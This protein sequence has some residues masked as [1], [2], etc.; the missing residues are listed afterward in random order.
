MKPLIL[1]ITVF[2]SIT[3]NTFAT[4]QAPDKIIYKGK[5][6]SLHT[7]PLEPYFEKHPDKKPKIKSTSSG[8][9]RGYIATFTIT[10]Q[11]M[12]LED[13]EIMVYVEKE[14]GELP[15]ERKSVVS[16]VIPKNKTLEIDWFTGVLVLPYGELVNYVHMGYGS[17]YESYILLEVK[18]GKVTG[19]RKFDYKQYETFKA[20]Q[21]DEYKKTVEYKKAFKELKEEGWEEDKIDAFLRSFIIRYTSEF[22]DK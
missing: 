14:E 5:E 21:F 20:K 7:N 13:I 15:F 19:K 1:A 11:V 8:C 3:I 17:T 16:E 4:A 6:Y 12:I 10:N 22:L 18:A 2:A 9:W